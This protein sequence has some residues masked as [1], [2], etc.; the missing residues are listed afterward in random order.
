MPT[1][2]I[3][4]VTSFLSAIGISGRWGARWAAGRREVPGCAVCAAG[5][6]WLLREL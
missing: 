2:R 6:G 5:S 1:D 3:H 4:E